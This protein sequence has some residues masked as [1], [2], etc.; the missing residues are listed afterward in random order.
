MLVAGGP[1]E[2]GFASLVGIDRDQHTLTLRW[3][4]KR[5]DAG[6]YPRALTPNDWVDP[7]PKPAVLG[8]LGRQVLGVPGAGSPNPVTIALLERALPRFLAGAGPSR[9]PV[10]R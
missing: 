10:P 8:E 9:R 6:Y 4:E 3:D 7:G 5:V 2:S 1:G